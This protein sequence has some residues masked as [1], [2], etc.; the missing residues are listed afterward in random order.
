MRLRDKL[1]VAGGLLVM[2]LVSW[3]VFQATRPAPAIVVSRET[4]WLTEPL[5]DDG[6]P[7][8]AGYLLARAREGVTAETNGAVPFLRAMWPAGLEPGEQQRVVCEEVGMEVPGDVGMGSPLGDKRLEESLREWSV[9]RGSR[10]RLEEIEK[11]EED[12]EFDD[13]ENDFEEV[14]PHDYVSWAWHQPWTTEEIPPLAAW[15]DEH[16]SHFDLLQQAAGKPTFY[17]PSP[18]L[19]VTPKSNLVNM[20]LT[21]EQ[22]MYDAVKC[23]HLRGMRSIG[24]GSLDAARND[25]EAQLRLSR[26]LKGGF[27]IGQ[28]VSIGMEN[29]ANELA[30]WMLDDPNLDPATAR[31]IFEIYRDLP[32]RRAIAKELDEGERL[33]LPSIMFTL[34]GRRV[35][36]HA[37]EED[38]FSGLAASHGARGVDWNIPLRMSNEWYD[39]L[40]DAATTRPYSARAA[41]F[42]QVTTELKAMSG[43]L[44]SDRVAVVA[45]AFLSRTSRSETMGEVLISLLLPAVEAACGAEDRS[46]THRELMTVAAALALHRLE[47]G[48]Y[49]QTLDSLIPALLQALPVDAY[50]GKPLVYRRSGEG[51]LLYAVGPNGQDDGGSDE[52]RS[53][54]EGYEVELDGLRETHENENIVRKLLGRPPAELL[55]EDAWPRVA[56]EVAAGTDDHAIRLPLP[57]LKLPGFPPPRE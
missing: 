45:S 46:N 56:S 40:V 21:S 44:S 23:L 29:F 37:T 28:L 48:E 11:S 24:E 13:E 27:L 2:G 47:H 53:I 15:V 57:K 50:E 14:D 39:R 36:P 7:D 10:P 55:E 20:L 38:E 12:F 51:Y 18:T 30:L 42:A 43:R 9:A 31:Q 8:Y 5:A 33:L 54:L 19:L 26:H 6:L 52:D 34:S 4:T 1:I 25:W 32:V 22:T 16:Q 3:V 35:D 17:A 41:K 49:P